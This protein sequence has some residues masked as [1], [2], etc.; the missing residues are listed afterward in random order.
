MRFGRIALLVV[1]LAFP[2]FVHAQGAKAAAPAKLV[3]IQAG[4]CK[5]AVL[6]SVPRDFPGTRH[7]WEGNCDRGHATGTGIWRMYEPSGK[8][9]CIVKGV[10]HDGAQTQLIESYCAAEPGKFLKSAPG[11]RPTEVTA[12]QV[13]SWAR[14]I[15][16]ATAKSS[17][18][19]SA[20][21]SA[22]KPPAGLVFVPAGKCKLAVSESLQRNNPDIKHVWEGACV[23][24]LA[25][26]TG[27]ERTYNAANRLVWI[28]KSEF[29]GGVR[30]KT[31]EGYS[32][33]ADGIYRLR[34]KPGG[35]PSREVVPPSQV[36]AWARELTTGS[37]P[38]TAQAAPP[39]PSTVPT[40]DRGSSVVSNRFA[41]KPFLAS[42]SLDGPPSHALAIMAPDRST[43]ER[44]AG[45]F[46]RTS[47]ILIPGNWRHEIIECT[48]GSGPYFATVES[49]EGQGR[50]IVGSIACGASTPD[51][52]AGA[53]WR[54]CK[55]KR[56]CDP[57]RHNVSLIV[58]SQR[59]DGV[60]RIW[61]QTMVNARMGHGFR[62]NL[63]EGW[64]CGWDYAG[65]VVDGPFARSG[66]RRD[67]FSFS[68]GSLR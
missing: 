32:A 48:G 28:A 2:T 58:S 23:Q 44:M 5:L 27:I 3:W 31:V 65:L 45:N 43:A 15:A 59:T 39:K 47:R 12:S 60:D 35:D 21:T 22:R 67:N 38:T 55:E 7:T 19:A 6:E 25:S 56:G 18:A 53:A 68:C 49:K 9:S 63:A 33:R 10:H 20:P 64:I 61:E 52:A 50:A 62:N 4:K 37:P 46:P 11:M 54:L 8:L 34:S 16:G 24:G 14:E 29:Q 1:W 66:S 42:L 13:S 26:G 41:Q 51:L 57:Q 30:S 36:P 40:S 17:V